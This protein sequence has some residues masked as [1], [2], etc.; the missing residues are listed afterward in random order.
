MRS[1]ASILRLCSVLFILLAT[2]CSKKSDDMACPKA[3]SDNSSQQR[4]VQ[5][6]FGVPSNIDPERPQGGNRDPLLNGSGSGADDGSISDDG[7][8][9]ADNEGPNKR[10]R[11]N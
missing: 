7:D 4:L 3:S 9:E 1:V 2:A 10:G 5:E 6:G 11:N 8:D